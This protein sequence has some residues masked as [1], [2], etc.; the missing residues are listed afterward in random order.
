MRITH[1]FVD[2]IHNGVR[3]RERIRLLKPQRVEDFRRDVR[4]DRRRDECPCDYEDSSCYCP[5]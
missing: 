1:I 4:E 3:K 2:V 5:D